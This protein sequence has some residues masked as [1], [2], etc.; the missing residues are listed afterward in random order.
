MATIAASFLALLCL[1][2]DRANRSA[3]REFEMLQG[4]QQ[5]SHV[6][7]TAQKCID[8]ADLARKKIREPE[9]YKLYRTRFAQTMAEMEA[10][11]HRFS[12]SGIDASGADKL[13]KSFAILNDCLNKVL[14]QCQIVGE[15]KAAYKTVLDMTGG[16]YEDFQ[17]EISSIHQALNANKA[18]TNVAGLPPQ[19]LLYLAAGADVV[20]LLALLVLLERG[21]CS[22]LSKLTRN[23]DRI[24][25]GELMPRPRNGK[26]EIA[27]LEKSF[28]E[29]SE[30]VCENEKRR[31]SFL[32]FFQSV[33][34]AS[35]ENVRK[36]FDT[37][38][39][40]KLGDRA[41]RNIQKARSN[42]ST[43]MQLLHSMTEALSFKASTTIN[44]KYA[45]SSST[46]LI[47]NASA[48]VE[49][50]LQKRN[51][52]LKIAD[53]PSKLLIDA[54]LIGRVL[55][56]LLSN[57]IKYSAESGEV[58]V[59]VVDQADS[60]RFNISDHGPGIT[61]ED[62]QKLFKEFSQV[63]SADGVKRSGTGL[64]LLIC[65]QIIEVHGG[66]V[67]VESEVGAGS[68]FWF[69][70]PKSTAAAK[71]Q[72]S[73]PGAA[74]AKAQRAKNEKRSSL[75]RAFVIM[76]LC[77]LIPQSLIFLRL[78]V[79]FTDASKHASR[80]RIEK[81]VLLESEELLGKYL[82]WKLNVAKSIDSM[83]IEA[84]VNQ[85]PSLDAIINQCDK[86]LHEAPSGSSTLAEINKVDT[87]M[88]KLKKFT[89]YI[90]NNKDNLN[91]AMM[92]KLVGRARTMAKEVENAIFGIMDSQDS[93]IQD[94]FEWSMEM[95]KELTTA[96]LVAAVLNSILLAAVAVA[97]L[98]IT[99]RIARL[100]DK[101]QDF[102]GGKRLTPSLSG[103]DELHFLD[104]RLCQVSQAIK[105]ADN[106]RQKLIA[107]INHDLRTPLSSI[108]NGLQ[109][110]LASGYSDIGKEEQALTEAA[111]QELDRLLQQINDLLLI[112]KIDAGHYKL[113]A[114]KIDVL[115]LLTETT[116]SFVEIAA[117]RGV[118]LLPAVLNE[119]QDVCINGDKSLLER[120]FAIIISNAV[121]AA[122]SGSTI[123]VSIERQD[124]LLSVSCKDK[125]EGID[126]EL[127]PQI[128]E[129]FRFVGGKPLTG[130][131]LP[132]AK[133]VSAIHGGSLEISSTATGTETRIT[134][135]IAV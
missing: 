110:I 36:C 122:P 31:H 21:I 73:R 49:A 88:K 117:L 14:L 23:C 91:F 84:V 51:I 37:L 35:L 60:L 39:E 64:G 56:N 107:V 10:I 27:F 71:E 5:V 34:S 92:P 98:R 26:N 41:R 128:F 7:K 111:E 130:L 79:M 30:L 124:Q 70:L 95:Q 1:D 15:N 89:A 19:Q 59:E 25:E 126:Q 113:S 46:E 69:E 83:K 129:R 6:I 100:K 87:G 47:A 55:V 127:L 86:M 61:S 102:A 68:C 54:H 99:E 114:E 97:G 115:S 50:L 12:L 44:P 131:G 11:K 81:E 43:L 22:P 108:M 18:A 123:D 120:E 135:P 105:D 75:K 133:R 76:L 9:Y 134:L 67:G 66:F 65:K 42:L 40:Q 109:L 4:S 20:M 16:V 90:R 63:E 17:R 104:L 116:N 72:P 58:K 78:Q 96:L 112:E 57:A 3:V 103:T 8:S 80:F 85:D 119:C 93:S 106:Q 13:S 45:S 121:K 62:Q 125:G 28:F 33:Q 38:L 52:H 53:T 101:S 118:K 132:L 48:A 2:V 94:S 82:T 77:L 24:T 32:E 74:Q 29:M